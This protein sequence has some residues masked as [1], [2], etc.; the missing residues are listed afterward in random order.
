MK[1]KTSL[2]IAMFTLISALI[3]LCAYAI[4]QI[5]IIALIAEAFFFCAY[6]SFILWLCRVINKKTRFSSNFISILIPFSVALYSGVRNYGFS[7]TQD[8]N[9]VETW[10][11]NDLFFVVSSLVTLACVLWFVGRLFFGSASQENKAEVT[12]ADEN[13]WICECGQKNTGKFCAECGKHAVVGS[14]ETL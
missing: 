13:T 12:E 11:L 4:T 10:T 14:D 7:N 8:I 9:V 2:K 3:C 6:F 1:I 5:N